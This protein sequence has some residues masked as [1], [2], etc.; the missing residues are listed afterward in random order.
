MNKI[1]L[2]LLSSITIP[3]ASAIE[4]IVP[5]PIT[6]LT[7]FKNGLAA[8]ERTAKPSPGSFLIDEE[9]APLHGTLWFSP[10]DGLAVTKVHRKLS[11]LNE[12]WFDNLSATYENCNVTVELQN[13]GQPN[14]LLTGT[15]INPSKLSPPKMYRQGKEHLEVNPVLTLK[16]ESGE[17]ATFPTNRIASIRSSTINNSLE[18]DRPVWLF[19][20]KVKMAGPIRIYYLTRGIYWE[21]S[22]RIELSTKPKLLITQS[23][24]INNKLADL[25]E[26]A[27]NLVPGF[28]NISRRQENSSMSTIVDTTNH[29]AVPL[30]LQ[31]DSNE[32]AHQ[33]RKT[34]IADRYADNLIAPRELESNHFRNPQTFSVGKITLSSGDALYL[35]L[36]S[37]EATCERVVEWKVS[38]INNGLA[39][40]RI[41]DNR[42]SGEPWDAVRFCNPLEYAITPAP[43]EFVENNQVL[44]QSE[45]SW[46]NPR[47]SVVVRITKDPTLICKASEHEVTSVSNLPTA[48]SEVKAPPVKPAP[49]ARTM[50]G[51]EAYRKPQII[52]EL[53][54][55]SYRTQSTKVLIS[56]DFSGELISAD[57]NPKHTFPDSSAQSVNRLN[58]LEWEIQLKPEEELKLNYTYT[59]LIHK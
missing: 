36:A 29:N 50:V 42:I 46:V 21:P 23:A 27:V 7:L 12:C 48:N 54:L 31:S 8:V 17:L 45:I 41:W 19:T 58:R 43:V 2:V 18:L 4:P 49:Q 56:L 33:M 10:S 26:V 20:P 11:K 32:E 24:V 1:Y 37:A 57:S 25:R 47:E 6:S 59:T 51:S 14:S 40:K 55:K 13:H 28:P 34:V 38:S 30:P 52:G 44:G 53:S 15:V 22:Y 3:L 39:R 9:L 35:P 5:A 16:L